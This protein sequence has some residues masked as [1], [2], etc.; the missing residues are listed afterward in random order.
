MREVIASRAAE[1]N[2]HRRHSALVSV[3]DP[4]RG[5]SVHTMPSCAQLPSGLSGG[6]STNPTTAGDLGHPVGYP[7]YLCS[8]ATLPLRQFGWSLQVSCFR[9]PSRQILSTTAVCLSVGYECHLE[10]LQDSFLSHF[11]LY[12]STCLYLRVPD[13]LSDFFSDNF[14]R[15]HSYASSLVISQLFNRSETI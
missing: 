5:R 13:R 9:A 11:F 2:K 14:W 4:S 10:R 3:S 6:V 7:P 1:K 12:R 15:L 8:S